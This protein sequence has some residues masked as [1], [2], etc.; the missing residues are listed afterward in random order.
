MPYTGQGLATAAH[1]VLLKLLKRSR[2]RVFLEPEQRHSLLEAH[3][4]AC[5]L[6]G[7]KGVQLQLDHKVRL[8]QSFGP[9]DVDDFWPICV[10][11]H[12]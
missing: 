9:Q 7:A 2:E 6:C 10:P 5:A 4:Y 12:T 11:C 3:D 1:Q 8:T